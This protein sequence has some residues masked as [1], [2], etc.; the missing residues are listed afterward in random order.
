MQ[1]MLFGWLIV[2]GIALF[3]GCGESGPDAPDTASVSGTVTLN[4]DPVVGAEVSFIGKEFVG[5]G[6]TDDDGKYTLAQGAV[7]GENL[8]TISKIE[9]EAGMEMDPDEGMDEGQ[10]EA[11]AGGDL[12]A[13][14]VGPKQLIPVEFSDVEK[15]K[16]TFNVPTGGTS[17]A[18]FTLTGSK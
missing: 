4:G 2:G 11:A 7:V 13:V 8:V 9:G 18:D 5:Y 16:L 10:F 3:S 15:S 17:S 12:D 6:K 14:D 1:R